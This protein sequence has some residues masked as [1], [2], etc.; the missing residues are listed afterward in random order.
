MKK[1]STY[2]TRT[3]ILLVFV[4]YST[5]GIIAQHYKISR[6]EARRIEIT[7]VFDKNPDEKALR[8]L[9]PYKVNIDTMMNHVIGISDS[10]MTSSRPESLLT[11]W[12]ADMLMNESERYVGFK[13]DLAV[14]NVGGLRAA[15]PKGN[16]TKENIYEIAPFE[17]ALCVV[18]LTDYELTQLFHQIAHL[19]GE[20]I[21]GAH[22]LI[23]K[24]GE[25]LAALVGTDDIDPDRRY[26]IAT[27]DYLAEGN[28]GM[29]AFALSNE[30]V[31][32]AITLRQM[33][34]NYVDK[35]TKQGEHINS[36]LDGRIRIK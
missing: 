9:K 6:I 34:L 12:V 11:N 14:I 17:N 13:P 28:D 27:V 18:V 22:L 19:G 21:S 5:I 32:P 24:N 36:K 16:I 20:G 26:K 33:L 29:S 35:F 23:D 8:I 7:S 15:M 2:F 4:F 1:Y 30:H 25:L 10:S 31:K 3:I